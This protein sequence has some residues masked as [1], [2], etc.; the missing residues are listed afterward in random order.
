MSTVESSV[1][2][3]ESDT[4]KVPVTAAITAASTTDGT[5]GTCIDSAAAD[6]SA[7]MGA[8][9]LESGMHA[10]VDEDDEDADEEDEDEE[11]EEDELPEGADP[12]VLTTEARECAKNKDYA[13]AV[14]KYSFA[15][16]AK[17]KM[18]DP[19]DEYPAESAPFYL[20][21]G[22]ALLTKEENSNVLFNWDKSMEG[23]SS[24]GGSKSKEDAQMA[25][26]A[27]AIEAAT[28]FAEEEAQQGSTDDTEVVMSSSSSSSSSS[29]ASSSDKKEE[30]G[31]KSA[32]GEDDDEV[33]D[34]RLAWETLEVAR[35]AYAKRLAKLE[36]EGSVPESEIMD[37]SYVHVR[38]GDYL[39]I[40]ERPEEAAIEFQKAIDLRE[41]HGLKYTKLSNL[42][43]LLGQA[44]NYSDKLNEAAIAFKK[45]QQ[46]LSD[47]LGG[48]GGFIVEDSQRADYELSLQEIRDSIGLIE[49]RLKEGSSSS[50]LSSAQ[51]AKMDA[52][53]AVLG[54]GNS[55][56]DAPKLAAV[57][58]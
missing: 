40:E 37:A 47:H 4:V 57:R 5:E 9:G 18:C 31:E 36:A 48:V 11:D 25:A 41:K 19:N 49:T 35:L 54:D 52:K 33:D 22:D 14:K 10:P 34:N 56:F 2:A 26:T 46:Y 58:K 23:S 45:A 39:V 38:L 1:P 30:T 13:G 16:E 42:Y 29:S 15:L 17:L 8:S 24:S 6:S 27:A 55:G 51:Q 12:D 3:V 44:L 21:Y 53:S 7:A 28:A 32:E 43:L 50:S 20:N